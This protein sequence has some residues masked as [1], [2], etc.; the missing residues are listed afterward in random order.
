VVVQNPY[1]MM[2]DYRLASLVTVALLIV[3]GSIVSYLYYYVQSKSIRKEY[4]E[5]YAKEPTMNEQCESICEP[6][7]NQLNICGSDDLIC[8][9]TVE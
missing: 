4:G 9:K 7:Y 1:D 5:I 6:G 3:P 8:L 2:K